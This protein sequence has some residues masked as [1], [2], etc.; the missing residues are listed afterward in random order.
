MPECVML[1]ASAKIPAGKD[2]I[3]AASKYNFLEQYF[4]PPCPH[5]FSTQS[6]QYQN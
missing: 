2:S 4:L 3:S 5:R 1:I 6:S